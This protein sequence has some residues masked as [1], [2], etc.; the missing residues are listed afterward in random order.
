MM[1]IALSSA[2]FL[3]I[4][5]PYCDSANYQSNDPSNNPRN[6]SY[7]YNYYYNNQKP[8]S[9]N[10]SK[11]NQMSQGQKNDAGYYNPQKDDPNYSKNNKNLQDS[12]SSSNSNMMQD[13][14]SNSNM[15]QNNRPQQSSYNDKNN[16]QLKDD[17]KVISDADINK[18]IRDALSS[19]WFSK[20]YPDVAYD[21]YNGSVNL[22]GT[23]ETHE[24]AAKVVD[25]VKMIDGVRQVN[26]QIKVAKK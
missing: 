11:T 18:K 10:G 1:S 13:N 19:G 12:R 7:W 8:K 17:R 21:V 25:S 6:D 4:G 15:M 9:N 20:G 23:V 3:A 22:K 14:R 2:A 5:C 26:N 24:D 16:K